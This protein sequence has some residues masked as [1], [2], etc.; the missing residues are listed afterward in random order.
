MWE[1]FLMDEI[2]IAILKELQQNA[3]RPLSEISQN[4]NLSLPAVSERVRKLEREQIVN[5]YTAILNPE[6]FGKNL[7][8]LCFLSLQGKTPKGDDEFFKFVE[9]EPDILVC[10][11][12]TGEYEYIL[13]IHTE[14]TKSLE[15]LLARI[16]NNTDV[17][18]TNTYIVLSTVKNCPSILPPASL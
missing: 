6:R 1:E 18:H 11:C 4:V 17:Q 5:Q 8:C 12:V 2:D 3:R 15:D 13:K 7:E 14:S 10:H 9:K 16:R